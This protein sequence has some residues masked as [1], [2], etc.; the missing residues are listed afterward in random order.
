MKLL[1][2][3]AVAA[4]LFQHPIEE[5]FV[6]GETLDFSVSWMKVTGGTARM[7]IAPLDADRYRIT[8][9]VRS[10]GG[11][12][13][14]FRIRDEIE[15]IVSRDRFSTLS[16]TKRLDERGDKMEEKTVV[17]DGVATRTRKKVKKI[18]VP[19]PVLDPFSVIYH[20]RRLD[21]TPGNS[22]EFTL[23]ADGKVYNVHARVMRR[24]TIQTPAGTFKTVM[25]EP[26]M[27][28]GGVAR[29]ERLFIWY[30]DDERRLPVRIRTEVKF[31]AVTANLTAVSEG[32]SSTNPP[33]MPQ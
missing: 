15:T 12:G 14:L 16:Y 31:G 17:E 29:E 30:S 5:T 22:W 32:V 25:V 6:R 26:Q 13:R 8:S 28:S 33:S 23:I 24:E 9:V 4:A 2:A 18:P 19:Y 10:G 1:L 3:A 7:T 27:I 11:I 21:L 20:V